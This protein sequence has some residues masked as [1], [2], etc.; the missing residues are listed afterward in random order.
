VVS[1]RTLAAGKLELRERASGKEEHR[2][3][4]ELITKL[5]V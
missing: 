2:S 4:A 1:E 3:E 5:N